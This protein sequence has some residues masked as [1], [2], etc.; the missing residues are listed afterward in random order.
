MK[1][2]RLLISSLLLAGALAISGVAAGCKKKAPAEQPHEHS[3]NTTWSK[4]E[5]NHWHAANCEHSDLKKDEAAHSYNANYVCRTCGYQHQHTFSTEWSKDEKGHWHASN[6]G[7]DG[8]KSGEAEHDYNENDVCKDCGYEAQPVGIRIFK[9]TTTYVLDGSTTIDIPMDDFVVKYWKESGKEGDTLTSSDYR[10]E[11]YKGGT[12]KLD[13]LNGVG[14]GSYDIYAYTTLEG[15]ETETDYFIIIR[16]VDEVT[17]IEFKSGTT[18]QDVSPS[19]TMSSSWKFNVTFK[20]GKILENVSATDKA[21]TV[22][23]IVT[24]VASTDKEAT[25]TYTY[26]DIS[27]KET[28]VTLKVPYTITSGG[29]V[30][31]K[32]II[33]GSADLPAAGNITAKTPLKDGVSIIPGPASGTALTIEDSNKSF[34]NPE[35]SSQDRSFTKRIKTNGGGSASQ[36]SVEFSTT[37]AAKVVV[38]ALTGKSTET[39][40][41]VL[42][43]GSSDKTATVADGSDIT[44]VEYEVT[45]AGTYYIYFSGKSGYIYGIEIL[46]DAGGSD[47]PVTPPT[48]NNVV[49]GSADLPDAGNIDSET[50]IGAGVSIIPAPDGTE[51]AKKL[52]VENSTKSFSNPEDS[53]QDRSFTKRIKT[54]GGGETSKRAVKIVTTGKAKIVVY[55]LT[56]KSTETRTLVL[57]DGSEKTATVADGSDITRVEYEVTDA[58]TCYLYFSG[59]SGYIYGIE[60][61]YE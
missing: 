28:K 10:L 20:S 56:G 37:G 23:G 61:I 48:T 60:I 4:D 1:K 51:D 47:T 7:H 2:S 53:S 11:Y 33:I 46:V 41:L 50:V 57:N 34:S 13:N 45:E 25:V 12:D 5:N 35:D 44:R 55:A 32:N 31:P 16:V 8:F 58:S 18:T 22:E 30:T 15:K 43:G 3:Y 29:V 38:Y 19:D 54:N 42:G 9:D 17:G 27:G 39:R 49:I 26:K 21:F 6:C 14:E 52:L 24:N 40:D 59:Q 36:R